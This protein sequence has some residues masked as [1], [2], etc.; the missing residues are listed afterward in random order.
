[1]SGFALTPTAFAHGTHI[2]LAQQATPTPVTTTDLGDGPMA[3]RDNIKETLAMLGGV[4]EAVQV[5]IDQG[6]DIDAVLD[7]A[8]LTP[9]VE[10]WATRFMT[11][12]R[13][14][15]LVYLDLTRKAE[16]E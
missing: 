4:M 11:E 2:P 15:R 6:K 8:P 7:A 3:T 12:P 1:M 9:W 10:D 13:F 16:T 14:T 5:E